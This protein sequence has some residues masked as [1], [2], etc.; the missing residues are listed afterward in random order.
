MVNLEN[1]H[2]FQHNALKP[3]TWFLPT[4]SPDLPIP[5]FPEETN[6]ALSLNGLWQF[7]FFTSPA[8]LPEDISSIISGENAEK[9]PVPGCW[10]L[11]GYDQPQ[12]LNFFYPF[13]VDP[14]HVPNENPTGVY[15]RTFSVPDDWSQ[16]DLH[17]TFLG[18]S[19]AFEVYLDG[20]FIGAS[21]GSRLISEFDLSPHL[22]ELSEHALTVVVHKWCAGAYLEDQDQ[23]R[24]HGIFRDVY[25]TARPRH[26]LEDV[27]FTADYDHHSG[28]GSLKV[29]TRSNTGQPLS[30]RIRLV[31]P[32]G[33]T[34]FDDLVNSD[35]PFV[36]EIEDVQPW[37]AEVPT[38]YQ[39]SL[40]TLDANGNSL[41]VIG[42]SVGFRS[43]EVRDQQLW[44]NGRSILLKG[45][46]HHEF[47]PDT[48]WTVSREL[49]EKDVRLM[50]Q[51]NINTVRNSHY[52]N[53]P[54]WYVLCDQYG[55]YLVD[56]ADLETHG[57][58]ITGD[59]A[60]LSDSEE[61]LPAYLDRA[62]R[63]VSANRNHPAII[64][65]SLGNE[66]G[67]GKNHERMA[68]WIREVDSTRPIHYEGAGDASFVDLVST[69]Y[70]TVKSIRKAG[71][72]KAEDSRPY[73]MCEYAHAMGNSP[74]SLREYWEAI[75]NY[76]RLVGG[77][78]WDW[79][80]QGL[81]DP[82][83]APENADFLYGGDFGD[84]P[85]DGNFCINGLIDPDRNPHPGLEELKFWQQPVAVNEINP[86]EGTITI[87]NRYAFRSLNHLR[88]TYSIQNA[89]E[90]LGEGEIKLPDIA[91]GTSAT[92]SLLALKNFSALAG[93]FYLNIQFSLLEP[94]SWAPEGHVV[95]RMQHVIHENYPIEFIKHSR[96]NPFSLTGN[97]P[98]VQVQSTSQTFSLDRS[99][100]WINSWKVEDTELLLLPLKLNIWRAPTDNDIHVSKEW[101]LDGLN[102]THAHLDSMV[103][104]EAPNEILVLTRGTLAADGFKPHS[105]YEIIYHFKSDNT[106]QIDLHYTALR[107][108]TRL[109][110]L[111]FSSQLVQAYDEVEW[112]GRGPQ[113]SYPD[114]KDSAFFGHYAKKISDL[115]HPYLRP[116]ENGNRSD[117]LWVTFKGKG[118]PDISFIGHPFINF[119]AQFISLENLTQSDHPSELAWE[120]RPYIYMDAAQTGLGSNACGPDTLAKY[121]LN[122]ED[123]HF[124]F[125]TKAE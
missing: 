95:A 47:D 30:T 78:V 114:R 44:L 35:I 61:W 66:S 84:Q 116:Q 23:W 29:A 6:R 119:N 76:P 67:C 110:R 25:L 59:W 98:V 1:P 32:S 103:V 43:I 81:R 73:F 49:M 26:H 125:M 79:V 62:E 34:I 107:L 39:M 41:E 99:T 33:E 120:K 31:S 91:A 109:P 51:A 58:Q 86:E 3:H 74:G 12:Y 52:P 63:M 123:L 85:N 90:V 40:E 28:F 18:V 10:E 106:L 117:V 93:P 77:C 71:E 54:Y 113:E 108:E 46:N 8:Y 100:G 118:S 11:S 22:H 72:N 21:Q 13:P 50:K 111:G 87:H 15:Q 124:S 97:G 42:F 24:L 9:I 19:S 75:Y 4:S 64:I 80:D 122:P 2:L 101:L 17:L 55:L 56:E 121:Q 112:L 102:R 96:N 20:E 27:Q 48:G 94:C 53:H 82:H 5:Y 16:F 104:E 37:S 65:W 115:Y 92:V 70:P 88:L 83:Q 105:A 7:R 60:E 45:V 57:F 36:K 14:P 89:V 69:M 68:A 38:L